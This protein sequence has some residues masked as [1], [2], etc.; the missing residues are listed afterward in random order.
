VNVQWDDVRADPG[1]ENR[2]IQQNRAI[3]GMIDDTKKN[4]KS[5]PLPDKEKGG[6]SAPRGNVEVRI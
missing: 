3:A 5:E 1:K 6:Y 2:K 4:R